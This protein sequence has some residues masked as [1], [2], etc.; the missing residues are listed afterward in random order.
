[1]KGETGKR[2]EIKGVSVGGKGIVE[3]PA[4]FISVKADY[5]KDVS[6]KI[7]VSDSFSPNLTLL[8]KNAK[9][10]VSKTGGL[11]AHSAIIAREMGMPAIVQVQNFEMLSEGQMLRIDG[12]T[13]KITLACK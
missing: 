7:L 5:S 6:G 10:V 3:G 4:V 1:M 2:S 12:A 8:Y 13:G 11:L 9:G